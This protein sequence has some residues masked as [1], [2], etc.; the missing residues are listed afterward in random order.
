MNATL[1]DLRVQLTC[2][3]V[4]SRRAAA[5]S[6]AQL[7][8]GAAEAAQELVQ[9][10]A[11]DDSQ[12]CEWAVS[13]LEE[14]GSPPIETEAALIQQLANP[15][16]DAAYW[17]ATLLGRLAGQARSSV[18]PLMRSM[19]DSPHSA[20]KQRSAWAL[21]QITLELGPETMDAGLQAELHKQ[22]DA[23]AE[24]GDPR[25]AR[26]ASEALSTWKK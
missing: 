16:A 2:H 9:A 19:R 15:K 7:G 8:E 1:T 10:V 24:A 11:D 25:L 13:A 22:L 5:Q 21:G 18:A 12:V 17:A 20:V 3:D 23:A 14:L 26:L 4:A 6:L